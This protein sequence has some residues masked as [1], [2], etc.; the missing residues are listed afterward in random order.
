VKTF[1]IVNFP[2]DRHLLLASFENSEYP[3]QDLLFVPDE[4][5]SAVSRRVSM[6]GYRV[7]RF[8]AVENPHSYQTSRGLPGVDP[9]ER[10]TFSQPRFA[11]VINR[12]GW[13]LFFKM[14]QALF[15]AVSV[16]LLACFIKP[17][18]V[19]P[20]FGLGVGALFAAVANSYLAGTYVP[21]TSDFSLADVVNLIGIGTILASLTQST[22]S[23]WV[24]ESLGNPSL[25]RRLD[26]VSF[27][28]ILGLF[29]AG[30]AIILAGA[31]S[32]P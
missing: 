26:R 15:V 5:A 2:L 27:W 21:D 8:Q 13:G 28:T 24:F 31:M 25:S 12:A 1:R 23:L 30:M 17:T 18:H 32:H 19:D 7:T 29:V 20:R 22:I 16:A 9:T 6:A 10:G 14:F 4:A 3:R 11:I